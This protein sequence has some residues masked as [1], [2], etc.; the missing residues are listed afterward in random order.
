MEVEN[1]E[2]IMVQLETAM[3]HNHS[4]KAALDMAAHD[5]FAK[6]FNMPLF[7]LLGGFRQEMET[8]IT[9]SLNDPTEMVCDAKGFTL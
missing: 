9:I 8:D 4:A 1:L 5:L 7:R 6:R 3:L 2:G